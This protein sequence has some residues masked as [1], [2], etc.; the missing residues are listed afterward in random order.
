MT[1]RHIRS[2][3][4]QRWVRRTVTAAALVLLSVHASAAGLESL[5]MPGPLVAA[6]AGSES[7]CSACHAPFSKT[8]QSNL[9]LACHKDV[10]ADMTAQRGLHGTGG[11]LANQECRSCHTDHKGR[12]ADIVGL[13]PEA[14]DHASTG[15]Q[16][17]GHHASLAC[18]DC[19]KPQT[20]YRDAPTTCA[21][22]HRSG[23]PHRGNLGDDCASCHQTDQWSRTTFD[24]TAATGFALNGRHSGLACESCHAGQSYRSTP[25]ECA[26]CHALDDVHKGRRGPDCGSCHNER[27]WKDAHFDHASETGFALDGAHRKLACAACHLD[28]MA[29][30][31]PPTGCAGCHSAD[32]VHRGQ[33]GTDCGNC[34]RQETWKVKFDHAGKTGFALVGAHASLSCDDCHRGDLE[35]KL[36]TDC[37]GC[38]RADDPHRGALVACSDC[39]DPADWKRSVRFDHEF[40]SFPLLGLHR[41]ATCEQCHATLAFHDTGSRCTDCHQREDVHKGSFGANCTSCHSPAG[42]SRWAFDHDRQ[43]DFALTGAHEG[44]ACKACHVPGQADAAGVATSC[45]AC[46]QAD[47][48]H[49]GQFGAHCDRCHTT[50]SFSEA[51]R[52]F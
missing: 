25:T 51:E 15:F 46:H 11:R 6:H 41:L 29:L 23:D 20:A 19:H 2:T 7:D 22:C 5:V 43:T 37:E 13:V 45:S 21:G 38:H 40:T 10:A 30:A 24:H 28:A 9:C 26:S 50:R 49:K 12:D 52:M 16:L 48:V 14:F 44:L 17:T 1:G 8:T 4:I 3:R 27:S 35:A 42:W 31:K 36:P 33:R 39:H 18:Q 34:H 47:D 32:D